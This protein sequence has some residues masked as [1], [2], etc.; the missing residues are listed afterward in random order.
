LRETG[1]ASF[2]NRSRARQPTGLFVR[3]T[4]RY[5]DVPSHTFACAALAGAA[6]M[7]AALWGVTLW[8][9]TTAQAQGASPPAI[10]LYIFDLGSLHSA[11][12]EPWFSAG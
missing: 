4:G 12:P 7:G 2:G 10:K 3:A 1:H 11:N 8:S 9:T 5:V 6:L